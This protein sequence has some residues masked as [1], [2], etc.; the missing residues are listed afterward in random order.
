MSRECDFCNAWILINVVQHEPYC[1]TW[2]RNDAEL[3]EMREN[4]GFSATSNYDETEDL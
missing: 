3:D 2:D 4:A 1:P